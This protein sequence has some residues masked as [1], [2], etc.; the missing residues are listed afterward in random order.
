MRRAKI[1]CS[2]EMHRR[3]KWRLA[4]RIAS[5]PKERWVR[6]AADWNPGFSTQIKTCRAAGRLRK[7][8]EDQVNDFFKPEET[9]ATNGSDVKNNHTWIQ[10]AKQGDKW[11]EKE[12]EFAA[13]GKKEK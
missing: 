1:P 4:M 2:I 6:K 12:Y 11:K 7:R 13:A 5:P 8:W 3:M 10:V 9:E